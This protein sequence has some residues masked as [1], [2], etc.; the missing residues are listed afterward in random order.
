MTGF[1]P[2][3]REGATTALGNHM[4][5]E[6]VSIHAPVKGR[7]YLWFF[8]FLF[9]CFNPRPREGATVLRWT[10]VIFECVSIHAPV[11]GRPPGTPGTRVPLRF[12]PRPREGATGIISAA[13]VI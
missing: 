7:L 8:F 13:H 6:L 4:F 11:K 3:P 5:T 10:W 1:N 9:L 2:R 12:N